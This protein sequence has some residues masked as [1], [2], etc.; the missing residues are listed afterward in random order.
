[1]IDIGSVYCT[2]SN[3]PVL[4]RAPTLPENVAKALFSLLWDVCLF[5]VCVCAHTRK[6]CSRALARQRN[7]LI[8]FSTRSSQHFMPSRNTHH[9]WRSLQRATAGAEHEVELK[10]IRFHFIASGSLKE[11]LVCKKALLGNTFLRLFFQ[12]LANKFLSSCCYI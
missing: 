7:D 6:F 1:M 2:R 12:T 5:C 4:P 10:C 9:V 3:P 11:L 8:K